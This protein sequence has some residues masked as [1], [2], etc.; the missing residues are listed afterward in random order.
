MYDNLGV[1]TNLDVKNKFTGD[2]LDS[3]S[4][5]AVFHERPAIMT[6]VIINNPTSLVLQSAE[7]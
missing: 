4:N 5:T 7:L 3:I 6:Q 2:I 1:K